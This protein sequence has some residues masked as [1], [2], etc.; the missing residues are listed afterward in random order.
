MLERNRE[1]GMPVLSEDREYR[2]V[3]HSRV[4][5]AVRNVPLVAR[6]FRVRACPPTLPK[7]VVLIKPV[8]FYLSGSF[9][10]EL[11]G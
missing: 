2:E 5:R 6:G 8:R 10:G 3:V 1:G 9:S 7:R 4:T 11:Y